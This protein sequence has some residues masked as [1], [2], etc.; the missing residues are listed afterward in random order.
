MSDLIVSEL[1]GRYYEGTYRATTYSASMQA[2]IA[3]A[4]A[5]G[6]TAS[7]TGGLVLFNPYGNGYNLVLNKVGIAMVV[8][9]TSAGSIGIGTGFS[10]TAPTGG[11]SVTPT[12]DK[13]GTAGVP[14]GVAWSA[15]AI[16]LP[17]APVLKRVLGSVGTGAI[18]VGQFTPAT[19]D[20]E[21]GIVLAPG[22]Y[23]CFVASGGLL[24][25]SYIFSMTWEE[26]PV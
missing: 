10:Q 5:T 18:T 25:S 16:T 15:A 2:V 11:T 21:G 13:V 12:S 14:T 19:I 8:A 17:N 26:V 23:A 9:Q 6:L 24:A 1:H 7:Y 20:L 3:T 4:L 22:G